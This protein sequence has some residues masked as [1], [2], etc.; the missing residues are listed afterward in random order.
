MEGIALSLRLVI[1]ALRGLCKMGDEMVAVGGGSRSRF[2]RQ[3]LADA[4]D[5]RVTKTNVGQEA[6]SLGAAAVAAVGA[7]L[8]DGFDKIDDVHQVEDTA[9][10][11][12]GNVAVYQKLLPVYQHA[13]RR[14]AEIGDMLA[15][16]DL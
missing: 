1:D 7:G 4:L 11:I 9:E 6:G 10:P 13:A 14:Q 16:L 2:W 12:A 15:E 8:W 5:I 3:I